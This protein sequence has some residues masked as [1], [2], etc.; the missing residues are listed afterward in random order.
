[1]SKGDAMI[2]AVRSTG[3]V[4]SGRRVVDMS[5][6]IDVLEPDSAPLTQLTKNEE[7]HYYQ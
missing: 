2:T 7:T 5:K 3:N 6:K 4:V 1:M